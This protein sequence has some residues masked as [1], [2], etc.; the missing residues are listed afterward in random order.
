[1]KALMI[2]FFLALMLPVSASPQTSDADLKAAQ[3]PPLQLT[4]T[5]PLAGLVNLNGLRVKTGATILNNI[6][7]DFPGASSID[8]STSTVIAAGYTVTGTG[9]NLS[10]LT[11]LGVGATLQ[12]TNLS[13]PSLTSV[14][15]S[16]TS[17]GTLNI[18]A[19]NAITGQDGDP[20]GQ[21]SGA[22]ALVSIG[23][24]AAQ[25][26]FSSTFTIASGNGNCNQEQAGEP[27]NGGGAGM[28]FDSTNTFTTLTVPLTV[29]STGEDVPDGF[30]DIGDGGAAAFGV[31][32]IATLT[33]LSLP[34]LT[35]LD[36]ENTYGGV[37]LNVNNCASLTSITLPSLTT[38]MWNTASPTGGAAN[39]AIN[40]SGDA[41]NAASVNSI[42]TTLDAISPVLGGGSSASIDLSGGTSA[43]PT[44]AGITA[45]SDLTS[46]N[47]TVIT[48]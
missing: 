37:A 27:T 44:D 10:A 28:G 18:S 20:N 3:F 8:T 15:G 35:T 6:P 41:L 1:M 16:I 24:A 32:G 36:S 30:G 13:L 29:I 9:L 25:P 33:T 5:G 34:V 48:N 45:A 14:L 43:T 21:Y 12:G 46:D 26:T 7:A 17:T 40:F 47:W 22:T 19:L 31:T 38:L 4:G 11:S 2:F 39:I 23:G 42:L